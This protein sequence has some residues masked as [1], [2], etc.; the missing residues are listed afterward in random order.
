MASE[1]RSE[2]RSIKR[3]LRDVDDSIGW[4]YSPTIKYIEIYSSRYRACMCSRPT[5][6]IAVMRQGI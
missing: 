4:I 6:P 1:L 5:R 2:A 3:L